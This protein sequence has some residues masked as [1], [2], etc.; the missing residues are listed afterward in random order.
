LT[1]VNI[2]IKCIQLITITSRMSTEVLSYRVDSHVKAKLS[3]FA[4]AIKRSNSFVV[5]QALEEYLSRNSWQVKELESAENEVKAG[6]FI[7]ND[8]VNS[9]LDS[10]GSEVDSD[11]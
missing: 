2:V 1:N 10:W 6:K 5:E 7:S 3:S 9:Y 8:E 4:K 11:E